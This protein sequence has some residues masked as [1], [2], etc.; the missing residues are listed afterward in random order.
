M[1]GSAY[2]SSGE[3]KDG[4]LCSK[5]EARSRATCRS[6]T[7]VL[8]GHFDQHSHPVATSPNLHG[9]NEQHGLSSLVRP[10]SNWPDLSYAARSSTKNCSWRSKIHWLLCEPFSLNLR[11]SLFET[12]QT[13]PTSVNEQML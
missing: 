4:R 1:Q 11:L 3:N 8:W 2:A 12:F 7:S 10:A 6:G 5:Q 13:K 9:L